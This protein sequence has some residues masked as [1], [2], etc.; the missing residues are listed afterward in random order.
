MY[1]RRSISNQLTFLQKVKSFDFILLGCVL[2]IGIISCFS[3]YSTDGGELLY[4]SKSH[5]VRFL[6]F[7]VMMLI[8][9]FFNIKFWHSTGYLFYLIVLGF[10]LMDEFGRFEI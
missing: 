4:H 3:M 9:S 7:F 2:L 1:Q 6:V 8:L 10:R 5:V